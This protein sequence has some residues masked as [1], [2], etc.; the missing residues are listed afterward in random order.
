MT[1]R[2]AMRRWAAALAVT[3]LAVTAGTASAAVRTDTAPP[4]T[5]SLT[6]QDLRLTADDPNCFK[7]SYPHCTSA[8]PNV[9]FRL[10]SRGD[11]SAC[12][13]SLKTT[14]GDGTS[15]TREFSGGP[16][17]TE[18]LPVKHK[19][20][21]PSPFT[22]P[23]TYAITWAVTV[24]TGTTCLP[25]SGTLT[26]VRTCAS[27]ALS[28][29]A[30]AARFPTSTRTADLA[31]GFRGDVNAFVKAM[32][33]GGISVTPVATLRPPQRAYLMHYAWLVAKKKMSAGK[34]PAFKPAQGQDRVDVCWQ[35][36]DANGAFDPAASVAAAQRL[37]TAFGIDPKLK[38]A[39]ALN[40]LHT[41]GL[42]IDMNTTWTAPGVTVAKASGERVRITTTPR[43]GLNAKLIAVGATYGVIHFSPPEKDANH[44]SSTGR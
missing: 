6:D 32:R 9:S 43:S 17:G 16:N 40:S 22:A 35:H 29:R 10:V 1:L 27:T 31:D 44:W 39:P 41:R 26:F 19:Y 18:L 13:F 36:T 21:K 14:W 5:V 24:L 33:N 37:V 12:T 11:T 8:D 28:G 15:S 34:V 38:V 25:S 23:R 7:K 30:W 2:S 20:T 42:A 3:A 4:G